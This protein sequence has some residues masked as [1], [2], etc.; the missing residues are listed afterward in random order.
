MIDEDITD[1]KAWEMAKKF[2]GDGYAALK[3]DEA[4]WETL[5]GQVY[6]NAIHAESKRYSNEYVDV[7]ID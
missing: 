7:R 3:L 2:S 5:F 1:K 6:G 4:A